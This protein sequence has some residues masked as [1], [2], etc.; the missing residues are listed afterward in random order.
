MLVLM[1][2]IYQREQFRWPAAVPRK[3]W[4]ATQG[5]REMEA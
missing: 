3:S 4:Y 1:A 2:A 5:H